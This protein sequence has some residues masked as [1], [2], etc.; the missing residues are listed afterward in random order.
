MGMVAELRRQLVLPHLWPLP[1]T[2]MIYLD[3]ILICA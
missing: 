1:V 2:Q 3:D